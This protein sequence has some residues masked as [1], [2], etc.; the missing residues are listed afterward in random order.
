MSETDPCPCQSGKEYADCCE[1]YINLD[2]VAP[3]PEALMRSR[4]TAYSLN[5]LEYIEQTMR[6]K[7]LEMFDLERAK[8]HNKETKWLKLEVIDSEIA[9]SGDKGTVHF[10]AYYQENNQN[11]SLEEISG[12]SKKKD[13]WYYDSFKLPKKP[14]SL[15]IGRNDPCF[16]GSGKKYKK[17]CG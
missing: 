8:D 10:K 12:F 6:G 5:K 14:S 11:H 4:Y 15:K 1:P 7:P 3:T 17:C 9:K 13:K 2:Q 16:C